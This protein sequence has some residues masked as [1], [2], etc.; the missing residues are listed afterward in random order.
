MHR[1]IGERSEHADA[2]LPRFAHADDAAAADM[3]AGIAHMA[4]RIEPLLVRTR[5]D[6]LVVELGRCVEVVIVVIEARYLEP[7]RLLGREH[8]E[9]R[10]GL[11]PE[12]AHALDH[13]THLVEVAVLRLA[14]GRAHAEA[15]RAR[16]ARSTRLLKHGLEAH[17]LLSLHAGLVM[18]AL[19]AIGAVL[20]TTAGLDRE[21]GRNLH[22]G[23]I[24]IFP[25]QALGAEHQFRKRQVEQ[26]ADLL[27]RPV[28]ADGSAGWHGKSF[29][30]NAGHGGSCG[31]RYSTSKPSHAT[32]R[33]ALAVEIPRFPAASLSGCFTW[34]SAPARTSTRPHA[35][36][37]GSDPAHMW[38]EPFGGDTQPRNLP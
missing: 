24:E 11:E 22:L 1:Q 35:P 28:V 4:E 33:P 8:A 16:R 29:N 9:R 26:R 25:V 18:R 3:N 30:G 2:V 19:R 6:D 5:R 34:Q 13:R 15:A 37:S 31:D 38:P 21:Q 17:Q 12:R 27:A 36:A 10:T 20:R 32:G 14:P 7:P 23:R